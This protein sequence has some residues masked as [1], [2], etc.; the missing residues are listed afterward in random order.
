MTILPLQT[1][2]GSEQLPLRIGP[3]KLEVY[4]LSNTS[5]AIEKKS[6]EKALGYDGPNAAWLFDLLA[7]INKFYAVAG[8]LFNDLEADVKF[9]TGDGSIK[10]ALTP[11]FVTEVCR[12]IADAKKF[13]YLNM[14]QVK[15]ARPA[16]VLHDAFGKYPL[17]RA[18][19]DATGL[20]LVRSQALDAL[21][22]VLDGQDAVYAWTRVIRPEFM[23]IVW[24]LNSLSW[25]QVALEPQT[26]A[27]LLHETLFSR[28][29]AS[30]LEQL[31]SEKPKRSY[32]KAGKSKSQEPKTLGV[33]IDYIIEIS[34]AT[35]DYKTLLLALDQT[36]GSNALENPV[37]TT[38]SDQSSV[39]ALDLNLMSAV[40]AERALQKR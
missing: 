32:Q 38:A 31:R 27:R 12:V 10:T 21:M 30:Q 24:K 9:Q 5:F 20:T 19:E 13:G 11:A 1:V 8:W 40:Q 26:A 22:Q 15:I 29:D 4:I 25:R 18:I 16:K 34:G 39:N 14:S 35:G 17:E 23:E 28:L 2:Y 3:L 33:L 7:G 37:K 6:F 36:L